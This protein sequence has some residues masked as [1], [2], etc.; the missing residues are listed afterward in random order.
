MD[1]W[2]ENLVTICWF[3]SK[4]AYLYIN[5]HFFPMTAPF[6]RPTAPAQSGGASTAPACILQADDIP[7]GA[8]K[9]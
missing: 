3:M 5:R 1:I 2:D 4:N 6:Q 9:H 8:K 7:V